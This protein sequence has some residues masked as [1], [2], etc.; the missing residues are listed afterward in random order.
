[1]DLRPKTGARTLFWV[2]KEAKNYKALKLKKLQ[3]RR[4]QILKT[5]PKE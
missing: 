1:M 4:Q 2:K 3:E 5:N